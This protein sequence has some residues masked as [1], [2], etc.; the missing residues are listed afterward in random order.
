[1]QEIENQKNCNA[2]LSNGQKCKARPLKG[3]DFCFFHQPDREITR[4]AQIKGGMTGKRKSSNLIS[5]QYIEDVKAILQYEISN[6]RNSSG[7]E[8]TKAR[9]IGSLVSILLRYF[10]VMREIKG[11]K[12]ICE[13]SEEEKEHEKNEK[14]LLEIFNELP[15]DN[16]KELHEEFN[17]RKQEVFHW[18]AL[19][20]RKA[21]YEAKKKKDLSEVSHQN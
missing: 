18:L 1:M 15:V 21:E 2:I 20:I 13:P 12:E 4:Q 6:V 19:E 11:S 8:V 10:E 14:K 9:T 3:K 5:V 7:S 17:R 16:R